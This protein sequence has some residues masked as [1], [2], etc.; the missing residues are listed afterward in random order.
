MW[1]QTSNLSW[2]KPICGFESRRGVHSTLMKGTVV[3]KPTVE[4]TMEV[5]KSFT[6]NGQFANVKDLIVGTT[7]K[8]PNLLIIATMICFEVLLI[9]TFAIPH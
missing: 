2:L 3:K 5:Y 7:C 1:Q 6:L 4:E 8:I 9:T